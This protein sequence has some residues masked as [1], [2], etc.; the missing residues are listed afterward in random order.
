M[1]YALDELGS[2][3]K[4]IK[5]PIETNNPDIRYIC[6]LMAELAYCQV[7]EDEFDTLNRAKVIPCQIYKSILEARKT[8]NIALAFG[9]DGGDNTFVAVDRSVVS[10]GYKIEN[11][12]F[13]AFRGT[14]FLYDWLIN[15]RINPV[16]IK[17]YNYF[18]NYKNKYSKYLIKSH[19][20]L[21]HSGFAEEALRISLIIS[22]KYHKLFEGVEHVFYSGHSL[23]GAIAAISAALLPNST[24]YSIHIIGAPRYC[25]VSAYY[26]NLMDVPVQIMRRGD[27]V[28]F[29]PPRCF[30]YA[31]HPIQTDTQ[32]VQFKDRKTSSSISYLI[33]TSMLF[34]RLAAKPHAIDL[35]RRELGKTA[36]AKMAT[37]PLV[38]LDKIR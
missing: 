26:S 31:D 20:G 5:L 3:I 35:Y 34:L 17:S 2:L 7:S 32:G 28:P 15:F 33:W 11:Y 24:T 13:V 37:A 29:V 38:D 10:I 19:Y 14:S 30:G 9:A 6:S 8:T 22:E 21:Y 27:I 25:D 18:F 36:N 16:S 23:G 1:K 4:K 12:L